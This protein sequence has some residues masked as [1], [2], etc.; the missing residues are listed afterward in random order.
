V[1]SHP[2][3][4]FKLLLE[5]E[6]LAGRLLRDL[7]DDNTRLREELGRAGV[8]VDFLRRQVE[9]LTD[10]ARETSKTKR[11]GIVRGS[12]LGL[13]MILGAITTNVGTTIATEIIQ[14]IVV[15]DRGSDDGLAVYQQAC[16]RLVEKI[17]ELG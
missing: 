16:E 10:A 2:Q 6:E 9:A 15:G 11:P 8:E 4:L 3:F 14:P 17:D 13:G 7:D 1:I 12:L 5:V